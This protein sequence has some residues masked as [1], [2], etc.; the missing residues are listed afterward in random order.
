MFRV[1]NSIK[2]WNQA[3]NDVKKNLLTLA[4]LILT[5]PGSTRVATFKTTKKSITINFL[6]FI[7]FKQM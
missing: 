4:F 3:F 1:L 6:G 5:I 2:V 7:N